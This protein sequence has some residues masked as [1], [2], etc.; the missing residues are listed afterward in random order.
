[1]DSK[2]CGTAIIT[3]AT[4]NQNY[5][6]CGTAI[7]T[8]ATKNK[9]CKNSKKCGTAI[10]TLATKHKRV[11]HHYI[12][13]QEQELQKMCG[14]QEMWNIHHY[15]SH[16][17]QGNKP[18]LH[19]PPR[20]RT[21]KNVDSKTCGTASITLAN[22]NERVSHHY[23][24]HPKTRT[25]KSVDSKKCGTAIITLAAKWNKSVGKLARP[26]KCQLR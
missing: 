1:V 17:E 3:L 24:G 16:Q 10:I 15:I 22:K 9:N 26:S 20:T 7:I 13:H 4:K 11:S 25:A 5:K 21:A 23:I 19:W 14:L 18:S 2:K 8:L 6:K 12:G